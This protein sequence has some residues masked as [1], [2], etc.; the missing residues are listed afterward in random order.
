MVPDDRLAQIVEILSAN[1][2][3]VL[4]FPNINKVLLGMTIISKVIPEFFIKPNS[5]KTLLLQ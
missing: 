5:A 4:R 2:I 1:G 3:E